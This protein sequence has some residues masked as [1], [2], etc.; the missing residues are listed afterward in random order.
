[1]DSGVYG[2]DGRAPISQDRFAV[3]VR[4]PGGGGT[5]AGQ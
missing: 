1:M 3:D 5:Q 4:R 2:Q